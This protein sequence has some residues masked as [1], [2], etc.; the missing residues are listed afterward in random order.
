MRFGK[1]IR[2]RIMLQSSSDC[3]EPKAS[4]G[5]LIKHVMGQLEGAWA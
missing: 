3:G 5:A 1:V 2:V 4:L